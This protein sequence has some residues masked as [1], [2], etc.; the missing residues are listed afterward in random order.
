MPVD[1][2]AN[3]IAK[4]LRDV[5]IPP[6]VRP[7]GGPDAEPTEE[8]VMWGVHTYAYSTI[9]H[10]RTI[11]DGLMVLAASG[12][13]QT[14][15]LVYRHLYEWTMH[16]FYM[17]QNLK[18]H[19][20][21][22]DLSNAWEL[23]MRADSANGWAKQHGSKYAPEIETDEIPDLL[24][25]RHLVS[26]Y[27]KHQMEIHGESDVRDSYGHLSEHAHPNG[28]CFLSYRVLD[29]RS[30]K[31]TFVKA[32]L[33]HNLGGVVHACTIDWLHCVYQLLE[34]AKEDTVRRQVLPILKSLVEK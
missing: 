21:D 24:R 18:L 22:E 30:N 26:A 14:M 32:P 15:Y 1:K 3:H 10:T 23:L 27:E 31:M 17:L 29:F 16:G 7:P 9:A 13:E 34:L 33:C 12:N 2:P 6:L 20:K 8:L 25:I 28:A 19:L 5:N 11:L 4:R